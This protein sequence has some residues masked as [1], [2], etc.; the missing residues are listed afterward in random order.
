MPLPN[1]LWRLRAYA[2]DETCKRI[3]CNVSAEVSIGLCAGNETYLHQ[4]RQDAWWT[5]FQSDSGKRR[6]EDSIPMMQDC[7]R[8]RLKPDACSDSGHVRAMIGLATQVRHRTYSTHRQCYLP[9]LLVV[10]TL[11]ELELMPMWAR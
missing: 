10:P 7:V 5:K 4:L 2:P 1:G 3:Q 6:R 8:G 9:K 11:Q